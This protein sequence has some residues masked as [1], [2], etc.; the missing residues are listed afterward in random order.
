MHV[1][2]SKVS[3]C[4]EKNES[5]RQVTSKLTNPVNPAETKQ[6]NPPDSYKFPFRVLKA[7]ASVQKVSEPARNSVFNENLT[8]ASGASEYQRDLLCG[9][10]PV[11]SPYKHLW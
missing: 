3:E 1:K 8:S 2:L 4:F 9:K 5:C 10:I 7:E 6:T 11:D